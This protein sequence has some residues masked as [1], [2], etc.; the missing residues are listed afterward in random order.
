MITEM[1]PTEIKKLRATLENELTPILAGLGLTFELG[2]A[3][4]D[5]DSVK[6]TGFRIALENAQDPTAKALEEEND[7]RQQMGDVVF[8]LTKIG[9][10]SQGKYSLVGYKPRNRKYPFICLN[11]DNGGHYKFSESQA[12]RMFAVAK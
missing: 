4:Y 7:F 3:R 12:E 9:E 10:T 6:F 1:N 2:N 8:D 11:L 5:N